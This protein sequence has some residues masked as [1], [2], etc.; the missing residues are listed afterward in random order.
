MPPSVSYS[1]N[2][3]SSKELTAKLLNLDLGYSVLNSEMLR[4][5][6][7]FSLESLDE[8]PVVAESRMDTFNRHDY[9]SEEWE[10]D[11][12][13]DDEEGVEESLPTPQHLIRDDDFYT[14]SGPNPSATWGGSSY[15]SQEGKDKFWTVS[16]Q[17]SPFWFP[18]RPLPRPPRKSPPQ[19]KLLDKI[20]R[21]PL[22]YGPVTNDPR[23]GLSASR[24]NVAQRRI[25]GGSEAGFGTF[26]WQAYIRIG[27]SRCGGSLINEWYVITAGHCVA[28]ARA[29]QIRITLGEYVLKSNAEP[30][31]GRTY[32]ASAIK[33]HPYFKFTPQADRY[34]VAVIR[35]NRRVDMAPHISPICLPPK[36]MDME[37]HHGLATGWGALK[38]GSRLRP[39]TLQVVD[40]PLIYN[41]ECERWHRDKG[42]N[43]V[44]Y[45]EMVCAGYYGGGKDSCQ[46]DSGGPLMTEMEGRWTLIGIV[47]AGYSCAKRGQPGIYHRVAH[48][49][50]WISHSISS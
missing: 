10:D 49:S 3:R 50:D 17:R 2:P 48:T 36:D 13:D 18:F 22:N 47:S 4:Q 40:V 33:V 9:G 25:V 38:P 35:L 1:S 16:S 26:P 28:R 31:P 32:G 27:T 19:K 20:R 46:G 44:I 30:L 24:R 6:M 12:Q 23:C 29:R 41:R 45:D 15:G 34:D 7:G 39:K 14:R 37:G 5:G 21:P 43:V 8:E 42:I 11:F